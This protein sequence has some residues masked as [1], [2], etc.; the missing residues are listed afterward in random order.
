MSVLK[1]L[2]SRIAGLVEGTFSR[3]FRSEV[4]PVEIARRLTREMDAHRAPLVSRVYAPTAYTVF[5]GDEDY[6]RFA[7]HEAELKEELS[8]YLLEHARRENLVLSETPVITIARDSALG[9]GEFGIK[10]TPVDREA[11][12]ERRRDRQ[13]RSSAPIAPVPP[14]VTPPPAAFT[15]PAVA[16][17]VPVPTPPPI[18]AVAPAAGGATLSAGGQLIELSPNGTVLGRSRSCDV[19]LE[20]PNASRQHAKVQMTGADWTVEDL[21]STNGVDVNGSRISGPTRL[22]TGD[23]IRLGHTDLTFKVG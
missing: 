4:R 1:T 21:G 2:E 17:P 14:R 5:L 13:E 18:P 16:V 8:S 9:L 15:P 19:V 6:D 3:A 12:G 7:P 22:A 23:L 11:L 10:T 20:D